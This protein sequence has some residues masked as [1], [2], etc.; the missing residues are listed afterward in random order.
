V[1]WSGWEK[2]LLDGVCLA[3]GVGIWPRFIEPRWV[4]QTQCVL[5][6]SGW[7]GQP[8]HVLHL[9]DL[10]WGP[11]APHQSL[12]KALELAANLE[13]DL[14]I[15]TGDF[16][17]DSATHDWDGL[18]QILGRVR[19]RF[20]TFACLGNHDYASYVS[21]DGGRL[22]QGEQG[23]RVLR[24]LRRLIGG[25]AEVGV[26]PTLEPSAPLVSLLADQQV[27]LLHNR[28]QIVQVHGLPL[29]IAGT[30]D[31][32]AGQHHQL[33]PSQSGASVL[34]THNP[35]CARSH[36]ND[37][38]AVLCGHTHGRQINLPWLGKRLCNARGPFTRGLYREQNR[39]V[40]VNRGLGCS[41]PFRLASRP[42]ISVMTWVPESR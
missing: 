15:W 39:W 31:P 5:P 3:S 36:L 34:L 1:G 42:E 13:P 12:Q 23:S 17:V 7:K 29:E 18:A 19:G 40:Y 21:L 27:D 2:G 10:H 8:I 28:S 30:G 9:S 37:W 35:D 26:F 16:L 41:L 6:L 22:H 11:H 20:G 32:W 33:R 25:P 4:E 24:I 38:S 14:V